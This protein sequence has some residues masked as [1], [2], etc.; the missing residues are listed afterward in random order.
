MAGVAYPRVTYHGA[1]SLAETRR[2][3][4]NLTAKLQQSRPSPPPPRLSRWHRSLAARQGSKLEALLAP[5][6]TSRS[7]A[8][9]QQE[10]IRSSAGA[11][12]VLKRAWMYCSNF[13]H[14][15]RK[16]PSWE[17]SAITWV[18][19]RVRAWVWVRRRGR[20][21]Q[22]PAR[23]GSG[24]AGACHQDSR[25]AGSRRRRGLH[26]MAGS[27]RGRGLHA[28]AGSRRGWGLHAITSSP[29]TILMRMFRS[30]SAAPAAAP[31]RS[32]DAIAS[33]AT[34]S[35]ASSSE[36]S[37]LSMATHASPVSGLP[38]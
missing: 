5:L 8:G 26:A 17:V 22:S 36:T 30:M 35:S 1:F 4:P 11:Q 13:L 38:G 31:L 34:F 7:S 37:C 15:G 19:V 28:M 27:R 14:V 3:A 9:A 32:R 10:L 20:R 29:S 24:G 6:S 18:R 21:P 16:P 33:Y 2:R 12:Q 23:S 25:R